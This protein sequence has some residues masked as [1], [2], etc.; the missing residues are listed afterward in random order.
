MLRDVNNIQVPDGNGK[1]QVRKRW[2]LTL[3]IFKTLLNQLV[4]SVRIFSK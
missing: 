2:T 3:G 4:L 1:F